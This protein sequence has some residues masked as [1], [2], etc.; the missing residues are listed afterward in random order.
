[1]IEPQFWT[2]PARVVNIVD[3]DTIDLMVDLGFRNRQVVRVRV[4]WIDT[5]EIYGV[6]EES[7]EF[8]RG[9]RHKAFA[10]EY[11]RQG[12]GQ[13]QFPLTFR[14]FE[15]T[16]KFGRWV[17]DVQAPDREKTLSEMLSS[18]FDDVSVEDS[19]YDY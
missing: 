17:G 12:A 8:K 5:A 9:Q 19:E 4:A 16:G 7:D 14:S 11:L 10:G 1:M 3:G 13:G 6:A 18:E 15:E 2:Y